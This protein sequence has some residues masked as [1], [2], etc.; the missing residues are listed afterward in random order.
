MRITERV[1]VEVLSHEA[2]VRMA[3]KNPG[4]VWTWSGGL[5]NATGHDV[6]RYIDNPQ[7]LQHCVDLYIWALEKYADDVCEVFRGRELTE[8]QFAAALSFHWNTGGIER[9]SWV[10]HFK[11]GRLAEARRA[12]MHWNRPKSIVGRRQKER[13]LFFKG[14][15]TGSGIITEYTRLK[16]D[17]SI[18]WKS[19]GRVDIRPYVQQALNVQPEPVTPSPQPKQKGGLIAFVVSTLIN[20]FTKRKD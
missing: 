20:L 14:E 3:Y 6:T 13:D 18:D 5:T 8:S 7:S 12:F 17:Y 1:A 15:W 9:A 16:P 10:K 11:A 2:I 4:D 19:G